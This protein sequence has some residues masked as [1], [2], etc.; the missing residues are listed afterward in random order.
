MESKAKL[1]GH[2]IHAMLIAFPLGMF[3]TAVIFDI[4]HLVAGAGPW[5]LVSYWM[6]VAGIVGGL[7]AAIFGLIDY[8]SIP[9][10][11]RAKRVGLLH[12]L[13]NVVL[14]ALFAVSA[15]LRHDAPDTPATGALVFS[16]LGAGLGTI[17]AWLGGE[18]VERMGVGVDDGAH[19][20]APSSLSGKPA[21]SA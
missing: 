20:D 6:I 9:A 16:F 12:G 17:T 3:V 8:L 21:R 4:L 15:W 11:T 13:G 1:F 2:S 5:A 19:L 14:V 7:L 18:L 10:A